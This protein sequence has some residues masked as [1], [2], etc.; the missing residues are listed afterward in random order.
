MADRRHHLPK[1]R[2]AVALTVKK[3]D[4]PIQADRQTFK[5]KGPLWHQVNMVI[6]QA[7]KIHLVAITWG[8]QIMQILEGNF[9]IRKGR[10]IGP[11]RRSNHG[12]VHSDL[13]GW[14]NLFSLF[15]F[16]G[17]FYIYKEQKRSIFYPYVIFSF[18]K[19]TFKFTCSNTLYQYRLIYEV[20]R[21][22]FGTLLCNSTQ[23]YA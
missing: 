23:K 2:Q 1:G 12:T 22:N 18:R 21:A 5:G 11:M 7:E 17:C 13:K 14:Q 3:A 10:A 9:I 4:L 16:F 20:K 15:R 19:A 6:I 8:F